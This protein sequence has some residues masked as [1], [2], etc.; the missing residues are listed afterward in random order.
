MLCLSRKVGEKIIV[1]DD[2]TIE[3][4]DVRGGR[5]RIGISAPDYC[6]IVR[7][8]LLP[9]LAEQSR[10]ESSRQQMQACA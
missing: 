10:R 4:V 7:E 8:E 2:I 6:A 1:G 9:I 5:V 3:V